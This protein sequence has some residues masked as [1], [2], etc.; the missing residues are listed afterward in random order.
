MSEIPTPSVRKFPGADMTM[1][2]RAQLMKNNFVADFRLLVPS[3][4][5]FL[6]QTMG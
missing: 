2:Q 6:V 4:Q 1:V 5:P 3:L